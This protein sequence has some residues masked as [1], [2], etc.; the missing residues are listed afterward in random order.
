MIINGGLVK[1]VFLVYDSPQ[2]DND[3]FYQWPLGVATYRDFPKIPPDSVDVT[4]EREY[5]CNFLGTVY[6]DSSRTTLMEIIDQYQLRK[7]CKVVPRYEWVPNET[8]ESLDNYIESLETSDL[9]LNPVGK[10][11]ECY[12][13]YEAMSLGSVPV[14]EDIATQGMCHSFSLRLFKKHKAPV[15]YVK[16]WKQLKDVMNQ[17]SK[18]STNEKIQRR[19]L[20]IDWYDSFKLRMRNE[21]IHILQTRFFNIKER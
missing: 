13:I 16:N 8:A 14:I 6:P 1:M 19:K 15:I 10:N 18:L 7:I 21:F 20:I 12:R 3:A 17:E 4:K 9:T 5:T 11:T 2:V